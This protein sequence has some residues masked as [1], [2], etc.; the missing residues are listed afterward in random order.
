MQTSRVDICY[1]PL[2]IAWAV[3]SGDREAFRK[4][5]RL[6]H[7]L[8]GGRFNPIVLVDRAEVAKQIIE[9]FRTDVII[10]VGE[11]EEVKEFPKRFPHLINPFFSDTLFLKDMTEATHAYVL[12]IHNALAHW[13]DTPEWKAIDKMGVK[14]FVWDDDDALADMLLLQYG[15]YPNA[16]DIGIDYDEI[17]SQAILATACR[18]DRTAPIPMDVLEHPSL[19]D[20]ARNGLRRHY[21]VRAGWDRGGFFVGDGGNIDD[22]VCFWN[23]RA[24]DIHLQFIDL[25]HMHRYA[26]VRPEIEKIA[27]ASLAHLDEHHRNLAVWSRTEIIGD[28][29]KHVGG[30]RVIH[31]IISDQLLWNGRNVRPPMMML[32][33]AS[34]L[35]V[36]GQEQGK[37][38]VSF[39]LNAKPFCAD[40]WFYTQHLVAS[41]R[42]YGGDNEHSFHPPY[43]PEWNEFFARRMHFEYNRLRIEPERIGI[44]IDAADHDTFVYGL[45]VPALVEQLF[46][47]VGLRAKLSS[48]GLIARQLISQLGGLGG[49]RVLK[50]PGVR[51]L[52][53]KYGPRD[54]FTKKAA[55]HLIGGKDPDNPQATFADHKHLYIEPREI[56]TELTVAMVFAYLV[57][58]GL[59]RIGTELTCPACNLAS[60]IALDALK[61]GKYLRAVWQSVRRDAPTCERRFSLPA[62]GHPWPRT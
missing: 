36:L 21:T 32:G 47:S 7:T 53:K 37:P 38:K 16:T 29:L 31:C 39:A 45:P 2:R 26:V 10:P 23:L 4:A 12:D 46:E 9:L 8:W 27:L 58:K 19:G 43:V 1:R 11:S 57:E 35:G 51:R 61:Q 20:L 22:L 3:H 28:V 17:L 60:W 54:A 62:N 44:I 13:R 34:S 41:V 56:G 33:E 18:I 25:A 48:G 59:F 15:A 30:Q 52:L 55:L 50:I 49:A 42:L 6:T 14:W 5:V 24:A 40:T